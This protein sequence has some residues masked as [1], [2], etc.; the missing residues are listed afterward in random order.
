MCHFFHLDRNGME[1]KNV[2][3][4][5]VTSCGVRSY[6]KVKRPLLDIRVL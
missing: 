5:D 3:V 4:R 2:P 6:G 1:I